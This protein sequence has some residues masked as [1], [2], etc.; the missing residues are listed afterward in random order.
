[1]LFRSALANGLLEQDVNFYVARLLGEGLSKSGAEILYSR[2][3]LTDNIGTSVAES[4]SKRCD[5]ANAAKADLFISIHCNS[6][7]TPDACGTETLIFSKGGEAERLA[8][9]INKNI[10]ELGLAD[11]GVKVRTNLG[12]LKN[13]TMPAVIVE[14]A[15]ISNQSDAVFLKNCQKELADSICRGVLE[16][17]GMGVH[18]AEKY[19]YWLILGGMNI[20]EKRLD[21]PVTRGEMFKL[22]AMIKGFKE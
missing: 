13:T 16:Y 12:V 1:M 18:W 3:N 2:E 15:F 17:A 20:A 6:A 10:R 14:L 19:Y 8:K 21:E 22:L 11:R 4:I 7:S 5:M 9:E